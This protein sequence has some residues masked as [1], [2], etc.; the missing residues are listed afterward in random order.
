MSRAMNID[1]AE[2]EVVAACAKAGITISA[3]EALPDGGTRLVCARADDA[4]VI[5]R[6]LAGHMIAG[7]VRRY[8]FYSLR[9]G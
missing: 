2:D 6:K 7:A 4:D 1:L 3:I 9:S 8:R 5:R